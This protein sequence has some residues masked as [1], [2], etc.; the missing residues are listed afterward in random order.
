MKSR[1]RALLFVFCWVTLNT[2]CGHARSAQAPDAE[3]ASTQGEV[4]PG[5]PVGPESHAQAP[6][7]SAPAADRAMT[8]VEPMPQPM[9]PQPMPELAPPYTAPTTPLV[10]IEGHLGI[11]VKDVET[12]LHKVRKLTFAHG[13]Q[14]I[15]EETTHEPH[16]VTA[17][18]SLRVPASKSDQV[19]LELGKLGDIRNRQIQATDITREFMDANLR[20]RNLEMALARYEELLTQAK[21]VTDLLQLEEH[22]TRL[23]G[24]IESLKGS[25]RYLKD[26]AARAT[27]HVRLTHPVESPPDSVF[28]PEAR[29]YPGLRVGYA[30]DFWRKTAPRS[31][32]LTSTG[33]FTAG[34]SIEGDSAFRLDIDVF[35]NPN[36]SGGGVDGAIAAFGGKAYSQFLGDG[37]KRW[38]EPYLDWRL[39]YARLS[40]YNEGVAGAGIGLDIY[41]TERVVITADARL[42]ALFFSKIGGHALFQPTLSA[43]TAF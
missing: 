37:Q 7:V 12:T 19:L 15:R 26:R 33:L 17:L 34:L 35:R 20:L 1:L 30:L 43:S 24:E 29:F 40:G 16:Q 31:D 3:A 18:L 28:R 25:L 41:K 2:G 5:T 14:V 32:Q 10:D 36:T 13:G 9:P 38:L 39:G 8:Q 21:S 4:A 11:E 22:I 23:R 6:A 42:H 27:F